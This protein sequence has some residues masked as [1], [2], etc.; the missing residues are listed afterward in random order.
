MIT[1]RTIELETDKNADTLL[2]DLNW[3]TDK[4]AIGFMNF[5][6]FFFKTNIQKNWL[7]QIDSR[8]K[9]FR[10][11]RIKSSSDFGI[12]IS[13]IVS[14]GQVF[15]DTERTMIKIDLQPN[16]FVFFNLLVLSIL[17][18]LGLYFIPIE[19]LKGS[20]W[21]ATIWLSLFVSNFVFLI[22]DLNKTES[23]LTEYF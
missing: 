3:D 8:Q 13:A 6:Y 22:R 21:V 17:T 11:V 1:L 18:V 12:K 7:G 2:T 5:F 9:T 20:W 16:A 23:K 15:T 14:R 4:V 10:I 19:D